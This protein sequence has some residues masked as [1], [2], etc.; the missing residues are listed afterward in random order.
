[1]DSQ[2]QL[3]DLLVA[4]TS[5]VERL[6]L[7]VVLRRIVE[8]GV[9][10]VGA[11]YGA[12]GVIS[13]EGGLERFIHVGMETAT[14]AQI[15]HLPTGRGVL[16]AVIA[17]REP[18]R[19]DHLADDSRSTG[20]P[21][22]H[23]IMDSFLG[24][25]VRVGDQVY[26][27]LYLTEGERGPFTDDDQNLIVALAATAGIAIENARLYDAA[28]TRELWNATIADVMAAMLD[29]EGENVLD[30]IAERVAALIDTE[31]VAVATP[32]GADRFVLSTVFGADAAELRGRSYPAAGTITARA[33]ETR[34]AVSIAGRP[35][36]ALFDW[37]P[38]LGPTV[39]IPLFAGDEPLGVLTVSRKPE[40]AAFTSADLEMAFTFAA[41]ASIA[42]EIV[43]ARGDR[44]RLETNRDRARIARDLHDH[45]IQRLFG[46]GLALQAVSVTADVEV[47]EAIESQI[48]V[49]D[50][51]I[52][53]IR[54]IIFALGSGDRHGI[55]RLRDRMLDVVA[56]A[57]YSWAV[58]PRISFSG[59]VDSLVS[60]GLTEDLVAVLRELLTN[61]GKYA[62]ARDVEIAVS[63][64]EGNVELIVRDDGI[65]IPDSVPRS[66]LS[67]IADRARLRGGD[68]EVLTPTG[69]GTRV[70]WSAPIDHENRTET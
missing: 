64:T 4:S 47:A 29:V 11:R 17:D 16:G 52:K 26:G 35:A 38:G 3:Q 50:S 28:R 57:T 31:L 42:L 22:H 48:D 7:E 67:N 44:H 19:L 62:H 51:T 65:G 69:G 8:A 5:I 54:T 18:I 43:R 55:K 34:R 9:N 68:C 60:P 46:A 13:R 12:L 10:L 70:R 6:D 41:Q 30:V 45:V 59:P 14:V 15:G 32:H 33:L 25:P 27:N 61:V 56:D 23:P 53:D 40:G 24:V 2:R 39:A 49:I 1:M 58:P 66:G 20:F 36:A 37:Q 63:A 21:D